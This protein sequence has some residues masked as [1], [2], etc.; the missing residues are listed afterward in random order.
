MSFYETLVDWPYDDD[1][2]DAV[3]N[4]SSAVVS[5]EYAANRIWIDELQ[6]T[7]DSTNP[8]LPVGSTNIQIQVVNNR[9]SSTNE[10]HPIEE[11]VPTINFVSRSRSGWEKLI[12]Y[13]RLL[14]VFIAFIIWIWICN[15][16]FPKPNKHALAC[17]DVICY[18]IEERRDKRCA[19]SSCYFKRKY[20]KEIHLGEYC[21][22][23]WC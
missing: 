19:E 6:H 10:D 14:L 2:F 22:C 8:R 9:T 11:I 12:Y 1:N 5:S 20:T 13:G 7:L 21:Y 18:D 17:A 16:F 3:S 4:Q 23:C 15:R